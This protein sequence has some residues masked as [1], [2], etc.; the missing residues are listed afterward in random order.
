LPSTLAI[1]VVERTPVGWFRSPDGAVLVARDTTVLGTP[2]APPTD[3]PAVGTVSAGSTP[4]ERFSDPPITL[5]VAASMDR[6]LLRHV[7][8]VVPRAPDAVGL[9]L[10]DGGTVLY[11]E[12]TRLGEKNDRL[13]ALLRWAR[14]NEVEIDSIDLRVPETP[15]LDPIDGPPS[16]SD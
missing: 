10:R 9:R 7:R 6:T 2:A 13:A 1:R 14:R 16:V 3:V 8:S 15:S 4:G 5:T 11:G 12:P